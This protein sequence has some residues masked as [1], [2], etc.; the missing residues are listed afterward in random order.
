MSATRSSESQILSAT[1]E[2]LLGL[3]NDIES[4]F[5]PKRLFISGDISLLD[6]PPRVAVIG[7]R[8]PS[9]DGISRTKR[10]VRDL[11][12]KGLVVVSGLA[13]G[14]DSIAHWTAI[15]A[16]GRTIAVLGT[17]LDEVYPQKNAGLQQEIIDK[18]LAI[19]Q[20]P[21]GCP[22][23]RKNFPLRNRTMALIAD[24]SIIVEAGESSGT[25]SQGWETLR[26]GKP[27]FIMKSVCDNPALS[28]PDK[29]LQYGAIV[30]SESKAVFDLLP[31]SEM[32]RCAHVDL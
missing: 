4:K 29:M 18:H 31:P 2:E 16:G 11:V 24:A 23:Q 27:L 17:P 10:I 6:G 1:P 14:V 30:L 32:N 3:L 20:F 5:A 25:H 21:K 19:S 22:I 7:T 13:E 8:K 26:L 9:D 28:W 12:K 15:Q